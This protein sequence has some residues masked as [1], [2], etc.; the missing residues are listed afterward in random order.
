MITIVFIAITKQYIVRIANVAIPMPFTQTI[1]LV[2]M[3]HTMRVIIPIT[4]VKWTPAQYQAHRQWPEARDKFRQ[5]KFISSGEINLNV[6]NTD[7][8]MESVIATFGKDYMVETFDGISVSASDW[9]FN[10]R[11]SNTESLV[12]LNVE[13]SNLDR[14]LNGLVKKIISSILA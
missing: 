4:T 6:S 14:N 9:R 5:K 10:I 2:I 13:S 3:H 8:I 12:R 11:K 1:T 7:S